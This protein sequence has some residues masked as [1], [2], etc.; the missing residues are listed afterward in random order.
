MTPNNIL[1][2]KREHALKIKLLLS[3]SEDKIPENTQPQNRELTLGDLIQLRKKGTG[4]QTERK[5][6]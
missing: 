1:D 6:S 5:Q 2:S 4:E 3:I